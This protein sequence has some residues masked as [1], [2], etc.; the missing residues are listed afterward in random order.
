MKYKVTKVKNDASEHYGKW[1]VGYGEKY[2]PA[3]VCETESEAKS[4]A[5]QWSMSYYYN[6]AQ[7]AYAQG[8][9]EGLLDEGCFGDYIC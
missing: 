4:K 9:K 6:Q 7:A 5:I 3:T 8:V 2:F 1:A